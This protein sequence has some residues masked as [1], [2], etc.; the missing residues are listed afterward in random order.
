MPT[1]AEPLSSPASA[2][3]R[4]W[5]IPPALPRDPGD[6][7]LDGAAVLAEHATAPALSLLLWQCLQD[8]HLWSRTPPTRRTSLFSSAAGKRRAGL[9][10]ATPLPDASARGGLT[11]LSGLLATPAGVPLD[12]H[13]VGHACRMV[14]AWAVRLAHT[15]T[16]LAYAQA[17]A[18]AMPTDAR[19]AYEMGRLARAARRNLR[20]MTW[21]SRAVGVSRRARDWRTYVECCRELGLVH[22]SQGKLDLARQFLVSAAKMARRHTQ[23]T[24]LRGPIYAALF[25]LAVETGADD[26][27]DRFATGALKYLPRTAPEI[28]EVWLGRARLRLRRGRPGHAAEAAGALARSRLPAGLRVRALALQALASA[29]NGAAS[30]VVGAVWMAAWELLTD[31]SID[32]AAARVA[33]NDLEA[34]AIKVGH[35]E[36]AT[37]ARAFL[38]GRARKHDGGGAGREGGR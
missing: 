28:P 24:S 19:A 18:L 14:S 38:R 2:L 13:S 16:A 10:R 7:L 37:R 25:R 5:R 22:E 30:D 17:A 3:S 36:S 20:A 4:R 33:G 11:V 15:E 21:L 34:A 35:A 26:E 29:E 32:L 6:A 8:V 23:A 31:G 1:H 12:A 9:L 27:A